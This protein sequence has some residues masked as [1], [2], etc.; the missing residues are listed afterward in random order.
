MF[1]RSGDKGVGTHG[2]SGLWLLQKDSHRI[3]LVFYQTQLRTSTLNATATTAAAAAT[4][5]SEDAK[6]ISLEPNETSVDLKP[7]QDGV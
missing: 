5:T 3:A 1:H 4:S 6:K 7:L 2:N